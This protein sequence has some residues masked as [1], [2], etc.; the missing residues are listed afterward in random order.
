MASLAEKRM[1]D[2]E[3]VTYA[4]AFRRVRKGKS[5]GDLGRDAIH[6]DEHHAWN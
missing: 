2:A 3:D 1:I 5:M 4:T 6:E